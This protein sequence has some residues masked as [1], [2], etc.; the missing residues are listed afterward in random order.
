MPP[1]DPLSPGVGNPLMPQALHDALAAVRSQGK[2]YGGAPQVPGPAGGRFGPGKSAIS[3]AMNDLMRGGRGNT[4]IEVPEG[5]HGIY[6]RRD[7]FGT[8]Q[9]A[10]VSLEQQGTGAFTAYLQHIEEEAARLG[11]GRI[12][13]ENIFNKRLIP[14]L[15]R[16]GYRIVNPGAA[17]P[18]AVKILKGP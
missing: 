13:V 11:S 7:P 4:W 8:F 2:Y 1:D 15:E 14:F 16:N 18:T 10:N 6:L 3:E 9:I 12:E 17:E 5:G